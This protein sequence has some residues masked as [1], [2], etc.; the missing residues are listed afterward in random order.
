[1]SA[2]SGAEQD[3]WLAGVDGCRRRLAR[4]RSCGRAA[5]RRALRI[6][7]RFADVLAGAGSSPRLSRSTCRSGCRSATGLGG[8]AAENC[9]RPLLGARQSSVF[10]VPSRAAIYA[11]EYREACSVA[12]ATS[13]PPRKV[14]KQL[15]NIAPKIREVDE[16]LRATPGAASRVFEVHPEVAFWRLNG[17]QALTEPK[18]VKSRCYEPG[19]ALRRGLLIAAGLPADT[20]QS[21]PPKGAGADDL[22]DARWP[23]PRPR[24]SHPCW[25]GAAAS[26]PAAARRSWADHGDLGLRFALLL[27]VCRKG[28]SWSTPVEFPAAPDR[29][30]Q[31]LH[32][33][34]AR[35]R[36]GPLSRA[37]R[38][39]PAARDHGDR[40]LRFPRLARGDLRRRSGRAVRGAQR[41]KPRAAVRDRAAL[42]TACSAALE[43]G[44]GALKIKHIVV[45][46]HA[47]CGGVKRPRDDAEPIS[48]GDFIGR[49][50]SLMAPAAEK[51][52]PRGS[53][54]RAEYIER[55]E[56][57]SVGQHARQ[58][59]DVPAAQEADRARRSRELTAPISAWR[60]GQT[61]GARPARPASSSRSPASEANQTEISASCITGV[62]SRASGTVITTSPPVTATLMRRSRAFGLPG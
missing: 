25:P 19:L 47:H 21:A 39:R 2:M 5:A 43:F 26:E 48:P 53:L 16:A 22:L 6:V 57:A 33:R 56:K 8:R 11:G 13:E 41:G 54:T 36:A 45:L 55:L 32:Q 42:I 12:L 30:L 28:R 24:T 18:K 20:V 59:A 9:V 52:G 34:P 44:I 14:S 10:S 46:G 50:M 62:C 27:Q 49:W 29:R 61:F 7:P 4:R 40:L 31:R 38:T 35:V 51:V 15:F 17:E 58:P 1:M 3:L 60:P 37:R 23:A